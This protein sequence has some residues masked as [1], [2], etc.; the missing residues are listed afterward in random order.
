MSQCMSSGGG[1]TSKRFRKLLTVDKKNRPCGGMNEV[2]EE[3]RQ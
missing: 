1:F 3:L 2:I